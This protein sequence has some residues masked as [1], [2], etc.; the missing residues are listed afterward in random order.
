MEEH[1]FILRKRKRYED[2]QNCEQDERKS[3]QRKSAKEY[4]KPLKEK[5]EV[6]SG[7]LQDLINDIKQYV[8][9]RF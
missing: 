8:Y 6:Y 9:F 4:C 2:D 5:H 1:W 3:I 7:N